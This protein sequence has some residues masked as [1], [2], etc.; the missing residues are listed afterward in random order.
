VTR[1]ADAPN[2][3]RLGIA[4]QRRLDRP[5][6][7]ADGQVDHCRSA[8]GRN[9]RL[10]LGDH[11]TVGTRILILGDFHHDGV[12]GLLAVRRCKIA[13]Q[14]YGQREVL[15]GRRVQQRCRLGRRSIGCGFRSGIAGTGHG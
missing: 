2:A 4:S 3:P 6:A 13:C 15:R 9:D 10:R 1:P 7:D 11:Q 12:V 8:S 5:R 14:R